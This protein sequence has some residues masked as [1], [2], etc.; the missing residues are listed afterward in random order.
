MSRLQI[1]RNELMHGFRRARSTARGHCAVITG[2]NVLAV[3]MLGMGTIMADSRQP[4][5]D[6][7]GSSLRQR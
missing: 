4:V 6:A 7:C 1:G 2:L 5:G 3:Y